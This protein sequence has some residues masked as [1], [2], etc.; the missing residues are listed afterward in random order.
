MRFHERVDE[1]RGD[2]NSG[3]GSDGDSGAG[4]DGDSGAGSDGNTAAPPPG[5]PTAGPQPVLRSTASQSWQERKSSLGS[6]LSSWGAGGGGWGNSIDRW[7]VIE[8]AV[9]LCRVL[10]Y[11]YVTPS[12]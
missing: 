4:S 9:C 2:G 5:R 1:G 7:D 12:L 6:V 3:A 10:V 8:D 11:G